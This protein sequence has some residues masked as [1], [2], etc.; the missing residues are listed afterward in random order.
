MLL[1]AVGEVRRG[2]DV[3]IPKQ[4]VA[5]IQTHAATA[6]EAFVKSIYVIVLMILMVDESDRWLM[7]ACQSHQARQ[8]S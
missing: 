3:E 6:A 4:R 7:K 5:I 8:K 1:M 2:R